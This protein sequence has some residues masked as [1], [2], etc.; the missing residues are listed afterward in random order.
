[1]VVSEVLRMHPVI[2]FLDRRCTL[3]AGQKS[4]SFRPHADFE[5]SNG[6]GVIVPIAAMQRDPR[7]WT[8]P[9]LFDPERFAPAN[10]ALLVPY[11]FL[12]FGCGPRSCL[13][14]RFGLLQSK[15]G[16]VSFLRNHY[17]TVSERMGGPMQYSTKAMF[18]QA[19]KGIYVN[20]VHDPLMK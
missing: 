8:N 4:Y 20:V 18:I 10:K 3:P 6:M 15:V 14:E 11:T 17:V 16:F 2:P 1:M 13:G 9:D 5:M 7:F 19:E 12:P